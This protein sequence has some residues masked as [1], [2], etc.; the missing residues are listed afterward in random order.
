L[1]S[2]L[3]VLVQSDSDHVLAT[4][5]GLRHFNWRQLN[6]LLVSRW[7]IILIAHLLNVLHLTVLRSDLQVDWHTS[8][9]WS[10]WLWSSWLWLVVSEVLQELVSG[11]AVSICLWHLSDFNFRLTL[12]LVNFL[13]DFGLFLLFLKLL[14]EILLDLLLLHVLINHLFLLFLVRCHN[15]LKSILGNLVLLGLLLEG[16]LNFLLL[17]L[18]L[19]QLGLG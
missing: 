6:S 1:V 18:L 5:L 11:A 19:V 13:E 10:S 16:S 4:F 14:L 8:H 12:L 15:F 2:W 9:L 3:L 17:L 7:L